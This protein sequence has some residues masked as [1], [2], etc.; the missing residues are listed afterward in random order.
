M[1]V[2]NLGERLGLGV[3]VGGLPQR[4]LEPVAQ[5]HRGAAR[6][7]GVVDLRLGRDVGR[8]LVLV[9]KHGLDGVVGRLC[10]LRRVHARGHVGDEDAPQLLGLGERR[11]RDVVR[12]RRVHLHG[13][14]PD[15]VVAERPHARARAQDDERPDLA[16]LD[17]DAEGVGELA[18]H[19]HVL[20]PGVLPHVALDGRG[21]DG[22]KRRAVLDGGELGD[23]VDRDVLGGRGVDARDDEDRHPREHRHDDERHHGEHADGD[24]AEHGLARRSP[25]GHARG[26]AREHRPRGRTRTARGGATEPRATRGL[27]AAG[28]GTGERRPSRDSAARRGR[29]RRRR[30]TRG[31]P[32]GRGPRREGA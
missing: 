10:A 11:R 14:D 27:L 3:D 20:D 7:R 9:G 8:Q 16:L 4:D 17:G 1:R 5:H 6:A 19:A 13:L 24:E 25:G 2:E 23:G 15:A 21:V 32:R 31:R 29:A 30:A 22:E 18:A 26:D 28:G 12:A